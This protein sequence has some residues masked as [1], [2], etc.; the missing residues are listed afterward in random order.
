MAG[1]R[2]IASCM[3]RV[4]MLCRFDFS[5]NGESEGAF[6]FG[7]YYQEVRYTVARV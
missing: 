4:R 5:G 6:E 2:Q 7:N 1:G 3:L